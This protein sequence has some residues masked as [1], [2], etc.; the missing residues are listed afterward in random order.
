MAQGKIIGIISA[1]GGVGKTTVTVN[2]G[3]ALA[4]YFG[5]DVLILDGNVTTGNVGLHLGMLY[6]QFTINDVLRNKVS[7][8]QATY[9]H[10]SGLRI[11]PA[12]LSATDCGRINLKSKLRK[13]ADNYHLTL[14]DSAPGLG[15]DTVAAIKASE[16]LLI[17]TTPDLPSVIATMKSAR[18][19]KQLNTPIKGIVLNRVT[20][21][22]HELIKSEVERALEAPVI[23]IIP[24]DSKVSE[25]IADQKP[26][27]LR[28]FN[29]LA[30]KQFKNLS[31]ELIGEKYEIRFFD[32]IKKFFRIR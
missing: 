28:N 9:I 8:L 13:I 27:V 2:L 15:K 24:E 22:N 32:K 1:K 12:S 20:G 23:G 30:S 7:I 21:K 29:S 18:L 5:K 19:A 31:A 10:D 17:V 26:I 11:I 16:E 6:P 25:A 3:A 4:K 14:L